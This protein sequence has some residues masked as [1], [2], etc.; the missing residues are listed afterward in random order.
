MRKT[1]NTAVSNAA[2][3]LGGYL[4]S[5]LMVGESIIVLITLRRD[6]KPSRRSVMSTLGTPKLIGSPVQADR[7]EPN[8]PPGKPA[9]FPAARTL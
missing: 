4:R 8:N 9:G 5:T 1:L 7:N 6:E 2:G 3:L